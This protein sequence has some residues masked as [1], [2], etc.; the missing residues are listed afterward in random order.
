[1]SDK[2]APLIERQ[3]PWLLRLWSTMEDTDVWAAYVKL[4]EKN[5]EFLQRW[6]K[7]AEE[8]KK[9]EELFYSVEFWNPVEVRFLEQGCYGTGDLEAFVEP[10]INCEVEQL[11]VVDRFVEA[12]ENLETMR[13]AAETMRVTVDGVDWEASNKYSN[14]LYHTN[15]LSWEDV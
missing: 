5:R 11:L 1:M 9:T 7:F 10:L 6:H 8:T 13:T 4:T 2:L 12:I 15:T 3:G 14:T